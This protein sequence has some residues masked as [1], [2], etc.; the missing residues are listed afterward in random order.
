MAYFLIEA[1][2]LLKSITEDLLAWEKEPRPDT[3]TRILHRAH[4]LKGAASVVGQT[5]VADRMHALETALENFRAG[6]DALPAE[7]MSKLLQSLDEVAGILATQSPTTSAP[8]TDP[9]TTPLEPSL[10]SRA[11][12]PS[13]SWSL[14]ASE[15]HSLGEDLGAAFSRLTSVRREM[16]RFETQKALTELLLSQLKN[17]RSQ[18]SAAGLASDLLQRTLDHER[19]LQSCLDQ[20]EVEM[21]QVQYGLEKLRLSPVG[22]LFP[23]LR[24]AVR[25]SSLRA[26]RPAELVTCGGDLRLEAS[27]LSQIQPALIQAIGNAIAHGIE[28]PRQRQQQGKPVVATLTLSIERDGREAVFR[29]KDDGRGVNLPAVRQSFLRKGIDL[30]SASDAEVLQSMLGS[31]ISTAREITLASGRGIGLGLIH[32]TVAALG[33]RARLTTSAREFTQLEL[34]VPWSR[35]VLEFLELSTGIDPGSGLDTVLVPLETVK[36]AVRLVDQASKNIGGATRFSFENRS[37]RV[38]SLSSALGHPHVNEPVALVFEGAFEPIALSTEGLGRIVTASLV[39][40]PVSSAASPII[41]GAVLDPQGK[42]QLVID[43][44][45]MS[46]LEPKSARASDLSE[47]QTPPHLLVIDDSLTTRSLQETVLQSAGFTVD[48]ACSGKEGLEMLD[49]RA[50]SLILV[51]V[52]MPGMDGFTF[53]EELRT[54]PHSKLPVIMVTS[55][56]SREDRQRAQTVGVQGYVVKSEYTPKT[57]LKMIDDILSKVAIKT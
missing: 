38:D 27:L 6:T 46:R 7:Q 11:T 25:E 17:H 33:G 29:L 30:T 34:R 5:A 16:A 9:S 51:D 21:R 42:V 14:A 22:S 49:R 35:V 18:A 36:A 1:S 12:Q 20:L 52:E 15:L 26:N 32:D 24:R 4:T 37:V 2:E 31:G 47:A 45:Q 53:V 40:I 19:A 56:N 50:Y 43:A 28:E 39:P 48:L 10:E 23:T 3:L 8:P 13:P 41:A 57:L 55:R 54:G 44:E